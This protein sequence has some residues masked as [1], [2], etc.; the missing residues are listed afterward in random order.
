MIITAFPFFNTAIGLHSHRCPT[1]LNLKTVWDV[2]WI[3]GLM[4]GSDTP[5]W[6]FIFS[7]LDRLYI[8][9]T[10]G[11]KQRWMEMRVLCHVTSLTFIFQGKKQI[12]NNPLQKQKSFTFCVCKPFKMTTYQEWRRC[13]NVSCTFSFSNRNIPEKSLHLHTFELRF[14]RSLKAQI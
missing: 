11:V 8:M 9:T 4:D 12:N 5:V 1:V 6:S 10:S 14:L 7:H 3:C 13:P 2:V